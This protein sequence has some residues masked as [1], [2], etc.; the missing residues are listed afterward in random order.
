MCDPEGAIFN[1]IL[2]KCSTFLAKL[3]S[4]IESLIGKS[5]SFKNLGRIFSTGRFLSI[6]NTWIHFSPESFSILAEKLHSFYDAFSRSLDLFMIALDFVSSLW[7]Q[8]QQQWK[9][10]QVNQSKQKSSKTA[11]RKKTRWKKLGWDNKRFFFENFSSQNFGM[12]WK[13]AKVLTF[14]KGNKRVNESHKNIACFKS[15][16]DL[17]MRFYQHKKAKKCPF[18]NPLYSSWLAWLVFLRSYVG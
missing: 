15:V 17:N 11:W 9:V 8:D 13:P 12:W 5:M 3:N 10:K 2:F 7:E 18:L 1:L 14:Y 6:S 4:F 16:E